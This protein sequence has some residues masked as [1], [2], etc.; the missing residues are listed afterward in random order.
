MS[1]CKFYNEVFCNPCRSPNDFNECVLVKIGYQIVVDKF[2]ENI[3]IPEKSNYVTL[4]FYLHNL[5]NQK[6]KLISKFVELI[7]VILNRTLEE[8]WR[9]ILEAAK[10]EYEGN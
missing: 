9:D 6:E 8:D 10:E 1:E 5:K 4:E 2:V 3:P 7:D